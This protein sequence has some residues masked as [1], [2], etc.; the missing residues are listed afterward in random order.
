[1]NF[2]DFITVELLKR[3]GEDWIKTLTKYLV[4]NGKRA[5]GRLI[6]SLDYKIEK[7]ANEIKVI[8]EGEDYLKFVDQGVDGV[9]TSYGSPYRFTTKMPPV[10][11]IEQWCVIKGIP[12]SAAFP[13][14]KNI[15]KF[16]IEPTYVIDSTN[17]EMTIDSDVIAKNIEEW[18]V[19]KFENKE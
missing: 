16:G 9:F 8:I 18:L 11:K 12:Q 15:F 2:N 3:F 17:Q 6:S 19:M 10:S 13:I 7:Q 5:S 14:A 1:M 4:Q